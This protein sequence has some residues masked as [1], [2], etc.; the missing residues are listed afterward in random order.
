MRTKRTFANYLDHLEQRLSF[1]DHAGR[2]GKVGGSVPRGAGAIEGRAVFNNSLGILRKD[3]PQIKSDDFGEFLK[4]AQDKGVEIKQESVP[5]GDLRPTQIEYNPAQAAQLEPAALAKPLTVSKD[6]YVLDGTNRY[7]RIL[8]DDES[9]VVVVNRIMLPVRDALSLMHKFP[10]TFSK[11][12]QDV[13]PTKLG[14]AAYF[15]RLLEFHLGPGDHPNGSSQEVHA[16]NDAGGP[17]SSGIKAAGQRLDKSNPLVV[18][19]DLQDKDYETLEKALALDSDEAKKMLKRYNATPE[20]ALQ[21][22]A[23]AREKAAALKSSRDVH[24][25]DGVYT[26]ERQALHDKIKS[27]FLAQGKIEDEPKLLLTG[28]LP[29]SGKS[30]VLE[31]E[32]YAGYEGQYV[33]I[34][35]DR[36]KGLL[37]KADGIDN[38]TI[39]AASYHA[40]ADDIIAN[41]F[42]EAL[43]KRMNIG[44]DG[45]MKSSGKMVSLAQSFKDKG[46]SVEVAFVNLD[47]EKAITRGIGRF[48]GGGRFVDPVYIASNDHKNPKTANDLYDISD[49]W[50]FWS[51]DVPFGSP[52]IL[53]K[54]K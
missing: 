37:A 18:Q 50:R 27:D 52:P 32:Q 16:G 20:E 34:D 51:N 42:S 53:V 7:V 12:V 11:S 30:S 17:H 8:T 38:V 24:M 44:L 35:S 36:I 49:T 31:S 26:A 25:K 54:E 28:G 45:T 14:M 19:Y 5:V 4:F 29:G 41:I 9:Q 40:E 3:M 46:Y 47:P 33:V 15:D 39:E 21:R 23:E 6:N 13:G 22:I 48:L 10:K 43:E 2:P 1:P